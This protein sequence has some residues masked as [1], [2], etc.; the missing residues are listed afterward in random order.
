M[1]HQKQFVKKAFVKKALANLK[2]DKILKGPKEDPT[3]L[4]DKPEGLVG[5]GGDP[6]GPAGLGG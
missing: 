3:V 6:K 2:N 4:G 1:K 5:L